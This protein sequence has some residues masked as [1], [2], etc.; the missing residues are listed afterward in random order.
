MT[1]KTWPILDIGFEPSP[2]PQLQLQLR[3]EW[4]C[5]FERLG[6]ALCCQ[7]PTTDCWMH[8]NKFRTENIKEIGVRNINSSSF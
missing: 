4:R 2:N 8:G 6:T 1:L 7:V 3:A 5:S